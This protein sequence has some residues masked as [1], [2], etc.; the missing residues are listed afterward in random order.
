MNKCWS[1]TKT[2]TFHGS[3]L[4]D[5]Q[6]NIKIFCPNVK[7]TCNTFSWETDQ[8]DVPSAGWDRREWWWMTSLAVSNR[9]IA[10]E[11]SNL[12][13]WEFQCG[14]LPN[15]LFYI[16]LGKVTFMF[17]KI[18]K[19][20]CIIVLWN[21]PKQKFGMQ[22]SATLKGRQASSWLGWVSLINSTKKAFTGCLFNL[23]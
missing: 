18:E 5:I 20:L 8:K 17:Y 16:H 2:Q 9:F 4:S 19:K 3:V 15:A 14:N 13:K 10:S 21:W 1:L 12:G 11:A 6:M 22:L 23:S 7:E